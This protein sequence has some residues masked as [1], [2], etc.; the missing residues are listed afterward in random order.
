MITPNDVPTN[1]LY[2]H[3]T[4]IHQEIFNAKVCVNLRN[5]IFRRFPDPPQVYV[6]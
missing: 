5:I 2:E 1:R 3:T 6:T 4:V